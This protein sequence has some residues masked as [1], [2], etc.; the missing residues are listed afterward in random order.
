MKTHVICPREKLCQFMEGVMKTYSMDVVFCQDV[1]KHTQGDHALSVIGNEAECQAV[2]EI[3]PDAR[4]FPLPLRLGSFLNWLNQ[5]KDDGSASVFPPMIDMGD[6]IMKPAR[7][8]LIRNTPPNGE[9]LRLTEKERNIL[10]YLWAQ[11]P[12]HVDRKSLLENVWGYVEGIE[13]H[14]LETHIYRL[15]QKI[16]KDPS[17]PVFLVTDDQGYRLV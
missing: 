9:V 2:V 3:H 5:N 8:E 17:N 4:Q 13:T 12:H 15:R 6:Y 1:N 11:R 10:M 16:E 14:T 7:L